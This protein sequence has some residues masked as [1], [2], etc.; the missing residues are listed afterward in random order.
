MGFRVAKQLPKL[1]VYDSSDAVPANIIV[2]S[3]SAFADGQVLT[4]TW[5]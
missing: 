1:I 2:N 3:S 4:I 5:F